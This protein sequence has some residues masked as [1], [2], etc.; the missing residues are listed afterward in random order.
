MIQRK[1]LDGDWIPAPG[2][3]TSSD[4]VIGS[5]PL[6]ADGYS[7]S[8]PFADRARLGGVRTRLLLQYHAKSTGG[9]VVGAK[10]EISCCGYV[11]PFCC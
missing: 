9:G 8:A 2:S 6:A 5:T 3:I 7:H 10:S 11:R 1:F 4:I